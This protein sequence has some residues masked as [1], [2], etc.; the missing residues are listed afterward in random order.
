MVCKEG[1]QRD[2][3]IKKRRNEPAIR[4]GDIF[5]FIYH[6]K[7]KSA[8]D[9]RRDPKL[10]RIKIINRLA[11]TQRDLCSGIKRRGLC[12]VCGFLTTSL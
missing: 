4:H 12:E 7:L 3:E 1:V 8:I 11:L 9:T 10:G 5:P 2:G 6:L